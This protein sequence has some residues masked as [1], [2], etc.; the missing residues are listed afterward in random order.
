MSS[1]ASWLCENDALSAGCLSVCTVEVVFQLDATDA[2]ESK[3]NYVL[4]DFTGFGEIV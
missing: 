1:G 2:D 4:C 3:M